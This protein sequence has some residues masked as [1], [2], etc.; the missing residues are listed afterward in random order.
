MVKVVAR[1]SVISQEDFPIYIVFL[2]ITLPWFDFIRIWRLFFFVIKK[3]IH[4]H[5][6]K[7][8]EIKQKVKTPPPQ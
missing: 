6:R 3:V 8:K 7:R 1:S 5:Y 4:A 2:R